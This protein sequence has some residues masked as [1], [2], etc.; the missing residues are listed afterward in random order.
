LLDAFPPGVPIRRLTLDEAAARVAERLS[1]R[2]RI[3]HG[4]ALPV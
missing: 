4:A 1:T 3:G 2:S